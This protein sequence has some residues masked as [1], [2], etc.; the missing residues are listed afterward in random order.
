M[1]PFFFHIL[2]IKQARQSHTS[3]RFTDLESE[4]N[5]IPEEDFEGHVC[6]SWEGPL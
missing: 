2:F 1:G 6:V 4:F 3:G 5:Q